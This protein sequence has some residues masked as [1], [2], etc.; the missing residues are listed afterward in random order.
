VY[1]LLLDTAN[2]AMENNS[3]AQEM[4]VY[5]DNFNLDKTA[6]LYKHEKNILYYVIRYGEVDM[7]NLDHESGNEVNPKKEVVK[8]DPIYVI[9]YIAEELEEGNLK[10]THPVYRKI[11]EEA[12]L[13]YRENGFR[14]E[15][16]FTNHIDPQISKIAAELSTDKYIESKIHSKYK[17]IQNE[18][19]KQLKEI[20]PYVV[21][22]YKNAV[23][24]NNIDELNR[25]M[26][27]AERA[28][29]LEQLNVVLKELAD[30]IE[31]K[32][33]FALY[34]RERIVTKI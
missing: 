24:Q 23:L 12:L 16:Y 7:M 33:Q 17:N 13:K 22:N 31:K 9:E 2:Q 27:E 4:P 1:L 3:A 26:Q 29:D 21:I 34:L 30:L 25:K 8:E 11:L 28:N 10:L 32:K 15:T 5:D 6:F 14:A 19:E 18:E 20:L